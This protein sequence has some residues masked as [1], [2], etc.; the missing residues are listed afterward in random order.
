VKE[1]GDGLLLW[2]VDAFEC[3]VREPD[4]VGEHDRA[5]LRG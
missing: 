5:G 2:F 3:E 1:L 4:D